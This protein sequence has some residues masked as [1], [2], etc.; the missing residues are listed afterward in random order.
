MN[1]QKK[2]DYNFHSNKINAYNILTNLPYNETIQNLN[3]IKKTPLNYKQ[4]YKFYNL[5]APPMPEHKKVL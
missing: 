4:P 1:F 2:I 5:I 3:L